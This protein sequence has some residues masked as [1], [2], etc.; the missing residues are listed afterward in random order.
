MSIDLAQIQQFVD[1][2]KQRPDNLTGEA[3]SIWD[4]LI[5][6]IGGLVGSLLDNAKSTISNTIAGVGG[7]IVSKV[8]N[9]ISIVNDGINSAIKTIGGFVSNGVN[10]IKKNINNVVDGIYNG[11]EDLASAIYAAITDAVGGLVDKLSDV[12]DGIKNIG[13]TIANSIN[14]A[15]SSIGNWIKDAVKSVVT[16]ISTLLAG[17][18]D[19]ISEHLSSFMQHV[20]EAFE[21]TIANAKEWVENAYDIV[22]KAIES[23]VSV[24]RE[25]WESTKATVEQRISELLQWL[26]ELWNNFIKWYNNLLLGLADKVGNFLATVKNGFENMGGDIMPKIKTITDKLSTGK[27]GSLDELLQDMFSLVGAPTA[28]HEIY[29]LIYTFAKLQA[30]FSAQFAGIQVAAQKQAIIG[31]AMEPINLGD[32]AQAVFRGKASNADYKNNA[33]LSG[34]AQN[35]A[36]AAFEASRALPTPGAIQEAFLRGEIKEEEHDKLLAGYGYTDENIELFKALYWI[37][38]TPTDLIR[39][40]VRE[41]FTPEIAERFGQFEDFPKAFV[42][43]SK[44]I[45]LSEQ[46]AKNYWAAHWDLPSPQM[47]FE[48]LHRGVIDD[49]ELTLLLRALDVM[50]YWR[51]R[52]IKISY[53]P[54]TRVDVRRMYQFGV[55][56][57]TQVKR[58]YLDLG[59]DEQRA[60]WL[61]EFTKRY[62]AP[63]DQTQLDEFK[64]LARTTYSQAYR[65]SI[66]TVDEYREH[67][68]GLKLHPDDVSLLIS[69]DDY[70]KYQ[71]DKL[72]DQ[73]GYRKDYQKLILDAYD[74]GLLDITDVTQMLGDLGYETDEITM[75][76]S[77]LDYNRQ[78]RIR[79]IIVNQLH[80]QYISYIIDESQAGQL[81]GMFNFSANEIGKLLEEWNIEK[82]FR[83]K[84]PSITDIRGFLNKGIITLDE[85]INELRGLG[86]HEKYINWYALQYAK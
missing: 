77:L 79:N 71:D 80:E 35:R 25:T 64:S 17:I 83:T 30:V 28:G 20:K 53:S 57:E 26:K 51:E 74:R 3:A 65:K 13:K 73:K 29:M 60:G 12:I 47:G 23:I 70:A 69:I 43:W 61:T 54:L 86:Y 38:P 4:D 27:Y 11:I 45:G 62:S 72:F 48:M 85:F 37:I 41:V 42:D 59:Y 67:L 78:L 22:R 6:L 10:E 68:L 50:P 31:L 39:M 18:V 34:I 82:S 36:N 84:Q 2:A 33:Y 81:F 55:I 56:D 9:S 16:S 44:K 58:A 40:A 15:L 14:G 5:K 46:W 52:L 63:E 32:M 66:I 75:E 19:D 24:L 1:L 21:R 8:S 49:K 76:L 7:Y